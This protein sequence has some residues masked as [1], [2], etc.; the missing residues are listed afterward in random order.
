[1][2]GFVFVHKKVKISLRHWWRNV[3][4]MG[5]TEVFEDF[6]LL[7]RSQDKPLPCLQR[8]NYVG[9]FPAVFLADKI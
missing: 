6:K 7:L 8:Q 2:S 4:L 3:L 9:T 5:I 1:M